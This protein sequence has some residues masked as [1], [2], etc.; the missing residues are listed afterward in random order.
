MIATLRAWW[1]A[2]RWAV[3]LAVLAATNIW[4]WTTGAELARDRADR[5]VLKRDLTIEQQRNRDLLR[6]QNALDTA[7][8]AWT[9]ER[10]RNAILA[11]QRATAALAAARLDHECLS[12]LV[13]QRLRDSADSLPA[14]AGGAADGPGA[15]AADPGNAA[16]EADFT[17][18][19][20]DARERYDALRGQLRAIAALRPQVCAPRPGGTLGRV[21]QLHASMVPC[22]DPAAALGASV[23]RAMTERINGGRNGLENRLRL[24]EMAKRAGLR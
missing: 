9:K 12:A 7:T 18:W 13:V 20:A 5:G 10:D 14:G 6:I 21:A 22:A 8:V 4:S 23:L 19:I 17:G 1:L 16:S 3:W 11:Q 15:A 2:W 24:W